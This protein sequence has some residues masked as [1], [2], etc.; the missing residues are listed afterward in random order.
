MENV[1]MEN[2][3]TVRRNKY[4]E[5]SSANVVLVVCGVTSYRER[6]RVRREK[7]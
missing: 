3:L 7:L 1:I 4:S 2:S 6:A 5:R